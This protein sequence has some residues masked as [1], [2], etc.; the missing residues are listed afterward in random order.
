MREHAQVAEIRD[1]GAG[2]S[3]ALA[4]ANDLTRDGRGKRESGY[5]VG[6]VGTNIEDYGL[7][8]ND[9]PELR[10]HTPR[11]PWGRGLGDNLILMVMVVTRSAQPT[12]S[13]ARWGKG[14]PLASGTLRPI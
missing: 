5:T 14:K 12:A 8:G 4:R 10:T 6:R 9:R 11:E 2:G 3:S 13:C 1:F 7:Q